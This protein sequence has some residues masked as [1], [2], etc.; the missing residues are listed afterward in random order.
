MPCLPTGHKRSKCEV[1]LRALQG[2]RR[3]EAQSGGNRG[4]A[5]PSQGHAVTASTRAGRGRA[6]AARLRCRA[7]AAAG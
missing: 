6:A 5:K 2:V 7:Q 3:R 1:H 4:H